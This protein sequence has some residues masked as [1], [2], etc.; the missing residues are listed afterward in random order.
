MLSHGLREV[1]VVDGE[2]RIVG[3][4]DEGDVFRAYLTRIP[5]G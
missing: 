1:P 4:V 2:G 3:F 5:K